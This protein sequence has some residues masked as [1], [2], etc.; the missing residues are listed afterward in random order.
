M[1]IAIC[2]DEQLF[3]K[4]IKRELEQY[5]RSLD[6][7]VYPYTSGNEFVDAVAE[8]KYDMVFLDI[9]MPGMN[10]FQTAKVLKERQPDITIIFL[11]SHTELAME[12]Y[13]VQAFRFLEK[14]V[15]AEK[16]YAALRA[17]DEMARK[18]RRIRITTDGMD[19]YLKCQDI[20]CIKSENV[21][22]QLVTAGEEFWIRRKKKEF[23]AEL[24]Q[25][26]FV[27]VHRSYIVNMRH[28]TGFDGK[29]IVMAD[30]KRIPVSRANRELFKQEMMQYMRERM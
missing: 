14:P 12:G 24:P 16:L 29:E 30:G 9:E 3:L 19:R 20:F 22:L 27:E 5:Y 11:T 28:V 25:D 21:Y 18:E 10:G 7:V 2:D 17:Y 15:K 6:V 8:R 1:K 4:A 13:E 23:L 26:M